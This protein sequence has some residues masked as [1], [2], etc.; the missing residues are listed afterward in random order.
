MVTV[1]VPPESKIPEPAIRL[2]TPELVIVTLP[3]EDDKEMPG[4]AATVDTPALPPP[5]ALRVPVTVSSNNPVP[6]IK[7]PYSPL[8]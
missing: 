6:T 1:P 7:G 4:P 8:M 3:V 5:V 2:V